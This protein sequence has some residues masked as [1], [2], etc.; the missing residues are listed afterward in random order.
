MIRRLP[1]TAHL[2]VEQGLVM[3]PLRVRRLARVTLHV[4]LTVLAR[5]ACALNAARAVPLAA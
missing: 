3:L 4:D 2:T 5:L 1:P